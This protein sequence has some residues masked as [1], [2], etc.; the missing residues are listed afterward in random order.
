MKKSLTCVI[1]KK[2]LDPKNPPKFPFVVQAALRSSLDVFYF[3]VPCLLH[4]LIDQVNLMTADEFKKFWE[5]IPKANETSLTVNQLYTGFTQSGDVAQNLIDGLK[6]NGLVN[7]AKVPKKDSNQVMLYFG[8]K[9][10]NNLPL[11][12]EIA[13]PHNG[14]SGSV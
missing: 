3:N 5:M 9:T 13:H 14:N 6:I 4:I 10:I 7:L 12:F 11:L 8:A 2:N 1:D